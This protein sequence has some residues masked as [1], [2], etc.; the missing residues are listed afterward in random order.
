MF[1]EL[2]D[3]ST[4]KIDPE[5]VEDLPELL[6]LAQ[7]GITLFWVHDRS[8]GQRKTRLLVDRAVPLI[9]RLMALSRLKITRPVIRELLS[10]YKALR[11]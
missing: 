1:R 8:P 10:L 9:D 7:L 2:V 11:D 4:T 3:G 6:W 5:L